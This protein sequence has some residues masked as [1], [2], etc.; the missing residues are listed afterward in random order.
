MNAMQEIIASCSQPYYER[1]DMLKAMTTE[2][3]ALR[4]T[5]DFPLVAGLLLLPDVPNGHL[6]LAR[7]RAQCEAWALALA[8]ALNQPDPSTDTNPVTGHP[9]R[10]ERDRG[11]VLVYDE[12]DNPATTDPLAACR[13]MPTED[14]P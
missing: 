1:V 12:A 9:Y 14:S 5:S 10:V 3:E 4:A 6:L 7:E 8:R 13:E 11:R 2:L